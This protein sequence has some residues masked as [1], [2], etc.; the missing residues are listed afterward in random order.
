MILDKLMLLK[1]SEN[2][3]Y[4]LFLSLFLFS[5]EDKPLIIEDDDLSLKIDTVSFLAS[6][7]LT[8]QV[9]PIIGRIKNI[10]WKKIIIRL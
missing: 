1:K 10:H 4:P 2:Y 5:C 6:E 3:L 9:P 8:Y 7:S